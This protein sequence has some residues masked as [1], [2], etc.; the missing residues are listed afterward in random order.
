[1]RI[2]HMID[3][4]G[5]GG[6]EQVVAS[7]ASR[8]SRSGHTVRI[9]CLRDIGSNP[10]DVAG[11]IDVGVEIVTLE[12]PPGFHFG[13]LRKLKAYLK[14][15][16]IEVVHTH[17]HLVHHYGAV[18]A[19]WANI[20]VILNTLHG[21]ASLQLSASWAK[22]LFWFSCLISNKVV[23]V[24]HKV[25]DII[26]K[27][28]LL[29]RMKYCVIENGINLSRFTALKRRTPGEVVTFG[30]IGRLDPVK[31]HGNLLQA[32]SILRMK[33]PRLRLRI[34]GDG[35]LR[36]DLEELAK[37]LSIAEDV[38]FEGFSLDTP[39][40][41]SNIDVYVISSH[42]EGLPLTLLEAMG[43]GLPIVATAVGGITEIIDKARCG[44]LCPPDSP[45]ALAA[46]MEQ[47]L[48]SSELTVIGARGR[49]AAEKYYS[50]E[51]MARDYE[52]LYGTFL[53]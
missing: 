37:S 6:A 20:P 15:H 2:A 1:M 52:L 36:H 3:D 23:S 7:L 51:R 39:S 4:L 33:Y 41:L 38:Y 40:F 50:A 14:S 11:L 47:A 44:W 16:R 5:C 35:E 42:S 34:L 17:N 25:N 10:I 8:Q 13:T 32:F 18:A 24:D 45:D 30:N 21:T 12:K 26:R 46:V 28:Y 48:E 22:V 19:R 31:G 53:A 9:I 43:A 49:T 27:A 29:P